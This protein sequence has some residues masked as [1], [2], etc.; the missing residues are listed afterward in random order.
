MKIPDM[1]KVS[2]NHSAALAEMRAR[3]SR[4]KLTDNEENPRY[5]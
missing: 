1:P 2:T 3:T 4:E 5:N